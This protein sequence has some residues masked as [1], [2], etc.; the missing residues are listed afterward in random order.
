MAVPKPITAA[1][2]LSAL[3]DAGLPIGEHIEYSAETDPNEQLGRPG[4]Y[5]SKVNFHDTRLEQSD[6]FDTDSGGSIEVFTSEADAKR[7]YDYVDG[8]TRGNALLNEYHWLNKTAFLRVSKKLT[9]DQADAYKK[10]L[11]TL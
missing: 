7:R 9:P 11:D 1:S 10:A 8:I 6:D 2:V 3:K 5:T 4:G